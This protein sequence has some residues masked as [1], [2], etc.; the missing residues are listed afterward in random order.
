M[1]MHRRK[2]LALAVVAGLTA[3]CLFLPRLPFSSSTKVVAVQAE[4]GWQT[5]GLAVAAGDRLTIT[6][7]SGEWSPWPGGSYD[8][9][10][11]GGDPLCRCNVM[12]AASHAALLGRIGGA[13]PFLVG[14]DYHHVTGETGS[15]L[16][17]INDVDLH[18]NSGELE[19]LIE[20]NR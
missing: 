16:L 1:D 14:R 4:E 10:G 5:T 3:A 9:A 2:L 7:L 17:A 13:Q 8:A 18:D 11:S 6:Y 12:E 15:L 19:V 20:I